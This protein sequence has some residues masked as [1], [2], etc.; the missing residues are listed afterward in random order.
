MQKNENE[1]IE[2]NINLLKNRISDVAKGQGLYSW[3]FKIL[4]QCPW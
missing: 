1:F 4:R 2:I 3:G